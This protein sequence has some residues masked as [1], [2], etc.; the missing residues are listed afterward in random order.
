MDKLKVVLMY[1]EDIKKNVERKY[2]E[3]KRGE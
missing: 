1:K 3:E 2:K